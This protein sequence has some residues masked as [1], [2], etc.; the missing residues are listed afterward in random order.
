MLRAHSRPLAFYVTL[1]SSWPSLAPLVVDCCSLLGP[2]STSTSTST[3]Y[4]LANGSR[5]QSWIRRPSDLLMQ[6]HESLGRLINCEL[7]Q[8]PYILHQIES[9]VYWCHNWTEYCRPEEICPRFLFLFAL[10]LICLIYGRFSV[11]LTVGFHGVRK[12]IKLERVK[13]TALRAQWGR[14]RINIFVQRAHID[15][16]ATFNYRRPDIGKQGRQKWIGPT[17][18]RRSMSSWLHVWIKS[19]WMLP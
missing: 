5:L 11:S 19:R 10:F 13:L 9:V 2:P 12:R 15:V 16:N 18:M 17:E 4:D 6:W 8:W 3:S 7:C 14:W 1:V